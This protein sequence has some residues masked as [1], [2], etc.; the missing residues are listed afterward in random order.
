MTLLD[1]DV[2]AALMDELGAALSIA[3][4][5]ANLIVRGADLV[6]ARGRTLQIGTAQVRIVGETKPCERMEEALPGLKVAMYPAWRGGAYGQ[7]IKGGEIAVGDA[8]M[9]VETTEQ[10]A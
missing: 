3:T 1:A 4:R 10:E 7:V 5:R 8:V 6:Q 2:W 9:W